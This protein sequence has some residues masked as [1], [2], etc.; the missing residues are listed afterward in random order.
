MP[1]IDIV[2]LCLVGAFVFFGLFFG[3]IHTLGSFIGSIAG[4]GISLYALGPLVEK[5]GFL[6]GSE[7]LAEVVI[8]IIAYLLVSRLVGVVFWVLDRFFDLFTWIPFTSFLNRLLGGILG[9]L[10]G[11]VIIGVVVYIANI[12]LPEG[13]IRTALDES[14][15]AG[16][17]V[18]TLSVLVGFLPEHIQAMIPLDLE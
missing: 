17:L 11:L 10:E 4:I 9:F 18:T 5:F 3:F 12:Y 13:V 2:L 15:A 14:W 1:I 7:G 8:F 6:F 16:Y